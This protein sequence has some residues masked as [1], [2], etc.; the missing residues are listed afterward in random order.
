MQAI[1]GMIRDRRK[2]MSEGMELDTFACLYIVRGEPFRPGT[3]LNIASTETVFGRTSAGFSPDF[4]FTNAWISRNHF[5]IR[6]EGDT[7]V[8]YDSGSRHGTE[9]NGQKVIP[10]TPYR[11]QSG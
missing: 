11:L 9:I 8:L 10:H 4:S 3:C 1:C 6:K 7:A 5:V 2:Q